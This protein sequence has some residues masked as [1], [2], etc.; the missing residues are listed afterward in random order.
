[1]AARPSRKHI[2]RFQRVAQQRLEEAHFLL[3]HDYVNASVYLAGYAV[4]CMLKALILANEPPKQHE[5]TVASFRGSAAHDYAWLKHQLRQRGVVLPRP[6]ERQLA[7]VA[8]WSTDL[9]YSVART[10]RRVGEQFLKAT[11]A[12]VTWANGRI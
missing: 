8:G 11:E 6:I 2:R 4:E 5:E 3:A 7:Q 9:R 12:I 1:M 10:H